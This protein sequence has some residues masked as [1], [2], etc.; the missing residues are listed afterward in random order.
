MNNYYF[1][2]TYLPQ[3]SF[4]LPPEISFSDFCQLLSDNLSYEDLQKAVLVRRFYDI[5]NIKAFWQGEELNPYGSL[6]ENELGEALLDEVTFPGYIYDFLTI[7]ESTED[8]LSHFPSLLSKFF[9]E[10]VKKTHGIIRQY[11][12]FERELRLVF[13][14]FRANKLGRDLSIELQ[15]ENPEEDIIAQMLAQK[16]A[17]VFEPPEKYQDLKILFEQYGDSPMDLQKALA[18]YRYNYLEQLV[19]MANTFSMNRILVYMIQLIIVE[20]WFALD[21]AEGIEIVSKMMKDVS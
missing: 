17:K 20:K 7:H 3:I 21:K 5:L 6:N 9:T 11:L 1:I 13:T 10:E 8:R 16:D 15:Y 14:G 18:Q 2:G 12:E 19:D 4:E